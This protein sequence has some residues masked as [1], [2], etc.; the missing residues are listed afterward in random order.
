MPNDTVTLALDGDV[1]LDV[2]AS[3]ANDLAAL[4][5]A[6]SSEIAG[7]DRPQWTVQYLDGGSATMMF[8]AQGS[9][10]EPP[11]L[12]DRRS[13]EADRDPVMALPRE[14]GGAPAVLLGQ[15]RVRTC[16]GAHR[17]PSRGRATRGPH[18]V[19]ADGG[20]CRPLAAHPTM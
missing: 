18:P 17:Q 1:S 7:Q 20:S 13:F 3:A 19:R 8:G 14:T 16:E 10:E 12:P 5:N 2:F 11:D 9:E 4:I 15:G 6:L